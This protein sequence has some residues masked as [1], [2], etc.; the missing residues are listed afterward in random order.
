[1]LINRG[2]D[3]AQLCTSEEAVQVG[4]GSPNRAK[5]LF[6]LPAPLLTVR[7]SL[8]GVVML[9]LRCATADGLTVQDVVYR[10]HPSGRPYQLIGN[11]AA[12]PPIPPALL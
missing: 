4:S 8:G 2:V 11:P 3:L 10:T 12:I 5:L 7:I 6:R 9:E 1:M